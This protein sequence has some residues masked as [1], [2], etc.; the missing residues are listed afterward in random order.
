MEIRLSPIEQGTVVAGYLIQTA[1]EN[2]YE[3]IKDF[4]Y[5]KAEAR[6]IIQSNMLTSKMCDIY[7]ERE[8]LGFIIYRETQVSLD[9]GF[10]YIHP[11]QRGRGIA[12]AVLK[13]ILKENQGKKV[14]SNVFLKNAASIKLHEK[15]GFRPM[16]TT[17]LMVNS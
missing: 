16:C 12:T 10:L 6:Q 8:N 4:G 7:H 5:T 17:Y 14:S 1:A 3:E 9:L 13:W 11:L 2:Y 15:I